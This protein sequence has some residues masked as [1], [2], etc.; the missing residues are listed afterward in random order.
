M[1]EERGTIDGDLIIAR[2]TRLYGIVSGAVTVKAGRTLVLHGSVG[3]DLILEEGA[4]AHVY[5]TVNGDVWNE[6]S[7]LCVWKTG[8]VRGTLQRRSVNK[9]EAGAT[10]RA[11]A[12]EHETAPASVAESSELAGF[13]VLLVEDDHDTLEEVAALVRSH[14]AETFPARHGAEGYDVFARVR[15][16]AIVTDLWMPNGGYDFIKRVRARSPEDGGLTPAIAMTACTSDTAE[17]ALLAGFHAHLQKP[18]TPAALTDLLRAF[19]DS[20]SAPEQ[21]LSARWSAVEREPGVLVLTIWD[22]LRA[23]DVQRCMEAIAP[24]LREGPVKVVIDAR[25][26]IGFDVSVGSVAE[27]S[28]WTL[29]RR[30]TDVVIVSRVSSLRLVVVAVFLGLGVKCTTVDEWPADLARIA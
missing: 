6:G 25:R 3:G 21:E 12:G 20:S 22:H 26:V 28:L 9:V 15:P 18:F 19:R 2:N 8:T 13:R 5:G 23:I 27:R 16:D 11:L 17:K 29:R 30:M 10:I 24:R 7:K 1:F 4:V 14:G